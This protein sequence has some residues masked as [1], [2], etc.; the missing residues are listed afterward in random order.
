VRDGDVLTFSAI[1]A[2]HVD[3]SVQRMQAREMVVLGVFLNP[4]AMGVEEWE[5]LPG[6]GPALAASIVSDR[7]QNGDFSTFRELERV[8]G[9]GEKKMKELKRFFVSDIK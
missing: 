5:S 3:I 1:D 4:N 8:N 9:I 2:E 7:Q 6:I